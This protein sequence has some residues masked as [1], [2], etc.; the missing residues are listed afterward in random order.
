M[1]LKNGDF[2]RADLSYA[3]IKNIDA[4][5]ASFHHCILLETRFENCN[6]RGADFRK[7]DLTKTC[8]KN[9]DLYAAKFDGA[10]N[11]PEEISAYLEN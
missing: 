9:V 3:L 10:I 11:I 8:F 1:I 2:Y 7:A 6:L 4:E 5:G